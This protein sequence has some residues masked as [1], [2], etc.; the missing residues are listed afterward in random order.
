MA[1]RDRAGFLD[2]LQ[3]PRELLGI[4]LRCTQGSSKR[5]TNHTQ[6]FHS[7]S[8]RWFNAMMLAQIW[9]E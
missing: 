9:L 3:R 1:E 2:V 4:R 8:P 6:V 7:R 5:K